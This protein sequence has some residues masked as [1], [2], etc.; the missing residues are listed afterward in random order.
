MAKKRLI[1]PIIL[2]VG[3]VLCSVVRVF[4]VSRTDMSIGSLYHG[5]EILCNV[6]YYGVIIVAA[7]V[8]AVFGKY[9][10]S[11]SGS[12]SEFR[13]SGGGAVATGF[14]LLALA[15]GAAYDGIITIKNPAGS[16]V[17]AVIGFV[18]A[19]AFAV[20]AFVTLYK[21]EIKPA[22]GFAYSFGGI[23]FV[24]KGVFFF[25]EHMVVAAIP[26]YLIEVL[27]I[28]FGAIFF[29]MAGKLFTGNGGKIAVRMLYACGT[30]SAVLTL[31]ALI[32]AAASKLF[33]GEKIRQKIVFTST[34]AVEYSQSVRGYDGY[35]MSF[36]AVANIGL[37]IMTAAV[38]I[39]LAFE[40]KA[41]PTDNLSLNP[42]N[43]EK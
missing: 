21:K 40:D 37:G 35:A 4:A 15:I 16:A 27:S 32:G 29:A 19:L 10:K 12:F 7:V 42:T 14:G 41:A 30:A 11:A 25:R 1:T 39:A 34:Q 6:L 5:S 3:I 23:Y 43:S 36:P 2:A 22:L 38:I 13:I 24:L 31:S 18:F 26:E 9:P 33:L 28:V 8:A 17:F 20:I